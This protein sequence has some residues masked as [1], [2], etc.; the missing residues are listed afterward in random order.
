MRIVTVTF[1]RKLNVNM[2]LRGNLPA[3]GAAHAE[4]EN[5]RGD[6]A[7]GGDNHRI[8]ALLGAEFAQMLLHDLQMIGLPQPFVFLLV[9]IN[10]WL[11]EVNLRFTGHL[12]YAVHLPFAQFAADF[13]EDHA[14]VMPGDA[15][16]QSFINYP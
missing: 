3:V 12:V 2:P 8:A 6:D 14:E 10:H 16:A 9:V 15:V 4:I 7:A 5:R 1:A 11:E 13:R